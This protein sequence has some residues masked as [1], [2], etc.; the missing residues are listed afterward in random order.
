VANVTHS[1]VFEHDFP[2]VEE[3]VQRSY[4]PVG[5]FV[6][7]QCATQLKKCANVRVN[8]AIARHDDANV[9]EVRANDATLGAERGMTYANLPMVY[10]NASVM[11]ATRDVVGAESEANEAKLDD[12]VARDTMVGAIRALSVANGDI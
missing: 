5:A 8:H 7:H 9:R 10:A 6:E 1:G 12:I 11:C 4:V 3:Q 2:H